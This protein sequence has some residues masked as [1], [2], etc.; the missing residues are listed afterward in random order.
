LNENRSP[1]AIVRGEVVEEGQ[2]GR[3]VEDGILLVMEAG[4]PELDRAQDFDTLPFAGDGDLGRMA[5]AAPGGVQRRVLTK[6]G[7]IGEDQ[8]PVLGLGFFLRLG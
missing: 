7:F 2:V 5:D 3:S 1:A 4:M 8:R 6:A